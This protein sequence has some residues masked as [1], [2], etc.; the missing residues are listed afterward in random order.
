MSK[1]QPVILLGKN[2]PAGT[3]V[4]VAEYRPPQCQFIAVTAYQSE[5]VTKLKV[6]FYLLEKYF[7]FLSG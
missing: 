6:C 4:L 1:Y 5:A 2:T 7:L 3:L